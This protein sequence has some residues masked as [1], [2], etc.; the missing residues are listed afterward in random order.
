MRSRFALAV[1]LVALS[2]VVA[3]CSSSGGSPSGSAQCPTEP[4]VTGPASELPSGPC[5]S[6]G[7]TCTYDA[8]PCVPYTPSPG[9]VNAYACTCGGGTWSCVITGVGA[10]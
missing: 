2:I 8:S 10:G 4:Y 1:T 7:L 9:Q 5:A 6:N 3:A